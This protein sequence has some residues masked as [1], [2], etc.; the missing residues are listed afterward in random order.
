[1]LPPPVRKVSRRS[2]ELFSEE[3]IFAPGETK[4]VDTH[5]IPWIPRI[6]WRNWHGL[7]RQIPLPDMTFFKIYESRVELDGLRTVKLQ[8]QNL[9]TTPRLFRG[10][11]GRESGVALFSLVNVEKEEETF[12]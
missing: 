12:V 4:L 6:H 9:D 11:F 8:V 2:Y 10:K 3:V 5:Y 7:V 1:M